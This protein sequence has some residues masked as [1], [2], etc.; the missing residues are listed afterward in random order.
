MTQ[1]RIL[2]NYQV[3]FHY[4]FQQYEQSLL[5]KD[6]E[7]ERRN[8]ACLRCSLKSTDYIVNI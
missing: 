5:N 1:E 4:K 2:G 3:T 8:M 7:N 6:K